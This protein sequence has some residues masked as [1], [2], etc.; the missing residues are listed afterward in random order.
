M[1]KTEICGGV[2]SHEVNKKCIQEFGRKTA[3]EE[4]AWKTRK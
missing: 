3:K 1:K 2:Y 4:T